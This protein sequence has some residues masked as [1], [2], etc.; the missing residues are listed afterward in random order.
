MPKNRQPSVKIENT[1]QKAL[2][3]HADAMLIIIAPTGIAQVSA[4]T[5]QTR[6]RKHVIA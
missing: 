5:T 1:D 6:M 2:L 3:P 4:Y